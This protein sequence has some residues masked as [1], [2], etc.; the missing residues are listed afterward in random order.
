VRLPLIFGAALRIVWD[1]SFA[2]ITLRWLIKA[3]LRRR[4]IQVT[5]QDFLDDLKQKPAWIQMTSIDTVYVIN[6]LAP[7]VVPFIWNAYWT[8]TIVFA[9][10]G[11]VLADNVTSIGRIT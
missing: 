6:F 4:E 2:I 7:Y 5:V 1:L 3:I 10:Q 11:H 8:I 9:N